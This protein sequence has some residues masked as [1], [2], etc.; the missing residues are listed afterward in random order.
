MEDKI[1]DEMKKVLVHTRT[2]GTPPA[3]LAQGRMQLKH[4]KGAGGRGP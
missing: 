3:T 4:V 2:T 1:N